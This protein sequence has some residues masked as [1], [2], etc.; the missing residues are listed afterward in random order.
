MRTCA[1]IAALFA[2]HCT[3]NAQSLQELMQAAGQQ[4]VTIEEDKT[5]FKPLGFLGSYRWEVHSYTNGIEQKDS[6]TNVVMAFDDAHMAMIPQ[7]NGKEQTRMV[8]DLK[9]KHTYT[10]M[11]DSKGKRSG[12]K[13]KGMRVVVRDEGGNTTDDKTHVTRTDETRTIEGHPCRKYTYRNEDGHG[14][15]WIAEDINFNAYEAL[16]HMVGGRT[17]SWQKAPYKG[18]VLE[19]VW[20]NKNGRDRVEMYT[21]DLVVGKVDAALFSITGY[22]VQDMTALPLFGR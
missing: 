5:P 16:G 3:S 18:M 22:E 20:H 14:E 21:R 2:L 9:N 19:S 13:M 4:S 7:A 10:L 1:L 8:F 6:P 11:T 12:V 17:D 15:A